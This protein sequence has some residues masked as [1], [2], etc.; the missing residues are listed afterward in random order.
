MNQPE[1][2]LQDVFAEIVSATKTALSLPVLNYQYGEIEELN[3]TLIQL[4]G[5]KGATPPLD[6]S[7]TRY[8]LVW[9]VEPF[10]IVERGMNGLYGK[11][12][13]L[14]I[15][16]INTTEKEWKAEQ[17]LTN[18]YKAVIWPIY[19]ELMNQIVL[20][21]AVTGSGEGNMP[22]HNRFDRYYANE[23]Q[24]TVLNDVVDMSIIMEIQLEIYNNQNC[25]PQ[26]FI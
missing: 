9:L 8:P 21:E 13:G 3:E 18:N 23:E 25:T 17:R 1:Y 22:L 11:A 7:A 20:H 6:L 5:T 14:N 12:E 10:K 2:I 19:R 24:K 4:L 16:I 15:V 26:I